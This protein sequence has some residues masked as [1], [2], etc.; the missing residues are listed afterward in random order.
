MNVFSEWLFEQLQ[1]R[2]WSQADLA[3]A[4]GLTRQAISY[5]TSDKSKSP[6]IHSLRKIAKAFKVPE[7]IVL[8]KAGLMPAKSELSALKRALIHQ[9]EQAD[10]DD[11]AL[12]LD[13]LETIS[14][15]KETKAASS[16]N[17][18]PLTP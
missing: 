8:E 16:P 18:K 9:L 11:A 3:R 10:E 15:R 14:R 12:V 1:E 17:A 2:N 7:D 13:F 6:D 4:S 5:Y